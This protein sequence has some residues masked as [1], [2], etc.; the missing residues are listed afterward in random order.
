MSSFRFLTGAVLLCA[1]PGVAADVTIAQDAAGFTLSNGYLTARVSKTTGDLLSIKLRDLELM[2][3][4]SGHHAGYW[5]QNPSR[6][7][8]L[9]ATLTIDPAANHGERGEVSIKG[10]ARDRE[11]DG[12]GQPGG[13]MRC[14]L[15]I[16]YSLGRD[17]H[18]LYTYAIFSHPAEYPATQIG[19]SRFG[20]KL[21]GQI[22]DWLSIDAR[23]NKLMAAGSDWDHASPLN[24]KE[25]RRFT[26]GIYAGQV[27]H[28]YDY[29]ALQFDIPAFGW[30]STKQ[31]I[32]FYFVNP[33][34]EYLSGGAT[35][36]E[37][38]GHLDNGD[39][40]DPTLLDYWRGT[41]YGGSVL[42]IDAGEQ[43][44]K[45]VG[46]I[47]IYVNSGGDPNAM[48]RDALSQAGREAAS[49]PYDWVRGVDYP[50]KAQRSTVSGQLSLNDPPAA[51][52]TLPNLLV[53]LAYP[54]APAPVAGRGGRGF[55]VALTWQNDAKHYEFWVRGT[56]DGRFTIPNVRAGKYELHAIADGV[57]G[58]F[59]K[60][61]IT[62][63]EG[64]KLDLGKLEWKPVRYGKQLWEIGVPNRSGAEFFKGDDYF[65]WGWYL[66][67]P[68]LFPKDVTFTIGK[69]D[70]RKD[71]FFEQVPHSE[72]DDP[73]GRGQG[74][75]TTWTINFDLDQQPKGRATLRLAIAG[76]ATR[77]IDVAVNDQHAGGAEGI[78]YNA[79]INRD[80]IQGSW[81]EKDVVFDAD[82]MREGHNTLTLTI[83][84]GGLTS[85]VIYDYIRLEV[86]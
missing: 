3:F 65:R 79:T 49:W 56:A 34:V 74:R 41:H 27:E 18:G 77:G 71:W 64:Q 2:G 66:E 81:L 44:S 47:M 84:A 72:H 39:G 28:K 24:M 76:A 53:G 73:A 62:V 31:H 32:G 43:W 15:E 21:N 59:A 40:G 10:I 30:S 45:V 4:D 69:S 60:A 54:D 6:A 25:A 19:E 20:V 86:Q 82:L 58:E 17:D 37:L 61:D 70:Y 75:A 9:S 29:S 12:S 67:Y 16:R 50:H 85:G 55:P 7:A 14:D 80:G 13:S 57:L 11:L 83:P 68:K 52:S 38:T 63:A 23:R 8:Q 33:S 22:F 26:T 1:L 78:P 42:R 51:S 36:V 5:E 35:K 46:P 48:Y